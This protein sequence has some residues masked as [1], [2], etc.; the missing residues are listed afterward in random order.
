MPLTDPQLSEVIRG[1]EKQLLPLAL[2]LRGRDG[3]DLD[4]LL[5]E[6]RISIWAAVRRDR[7]P[8]LDVAFKRMQNWVRHIQLQNPAAYEDMLELGELDR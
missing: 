6:G 4:D 2:R 8:S 7:V 3:A 5:Q 1:Y